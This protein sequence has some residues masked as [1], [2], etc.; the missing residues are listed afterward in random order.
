MEA[1]AEGFLYPHT[2]IKRCTDCNMCNRVCPVITRKDSQ[3]RLQF[4]TSTKAYAAYNEDEVIRLLSSSGGIF[5]ALATSVIENGGLVFGAAWA[6]HEIKHIKIESLDE[7]PLLRG[8]KYSQSSLYETFKEIIELLKQ[9]RLILFSGTPCQIAGLKGYLRHDYE[10]LLLVE[11]ACHGTPSPKVLKRYIEELQ[12]IYGEEC[13]LD[14]RSKADGDWNNYKVTAFDHTKHYFYETQKENIFMKGYLGELYS[15]PICHE[16]PFKAGLSGAD[17]T[18]ADFWGIENV[19]PLFFTK[20]GVNLALT[21]SD[22]G[23]LYLNNLQHIRRQT[24][25]VNLAVKHNGALLHSEKPHP[26]RKYFFTYLNKRKFS[27]LT[28]KC[29][30]IRPTTRLR[31]LAISIWHKMTKSTFNNINVAK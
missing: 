6:T 31:L 15:R 16:C 14:F 22:K 12:H 21:H 17:I 28:N 3:Q 27:E 9:G 26:D 29:L 5:S 24:V 25:P 23:E 20:S 7:L 18:L 10:N 19:S 4:P 8:S 2:D 30:N 11:V 1:D 13:Q